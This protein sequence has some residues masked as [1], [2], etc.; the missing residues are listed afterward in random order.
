MYSSIKIL[1]HTT[2]LL[3]SQIHNNLKD[4][5]YDFMEKYKGTV[6]SNW[7]I[8]ARFIRFKINLIFMWILIMWSVFLHMPEQT[9]RGQMKTLKDRFPHYIFVWIP[10]TRLRLSCLQ[11][12]DF[13]HS[14]VLPACP[15]INFKERNWTFLLFSYHPNRTSSLFFISFFSPHFK[16]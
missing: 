3:L 1:L 4:H 11:G 10:E 5:V 12:K 7:I 16:I 2:N 6:I 9:W 13:T 15:L 14:V 8:S